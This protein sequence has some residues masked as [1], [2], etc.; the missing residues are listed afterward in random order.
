VNPT[1]AERSAARG[2]IAPFISVSAGSGWSSETSDIQKS[3]A[4][5][6]AS[7]DEIDSAPRLNWLKPIDRR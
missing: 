4:F 1:T 6:S 3:T 7:S 2:V 5:H